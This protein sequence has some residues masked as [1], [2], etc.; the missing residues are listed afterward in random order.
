MRLTCVILRPRVLRA[1][2]FQR[3]RLLLEVLAGLAL[4]SV[5]CC[6]LRP[7]SATG[8]SESSVRHYCRGCRH[9][10]A[11]LDVA[12]SPQPLAA[13][14]GAATARGGAGSAGRSAASTACRRLL[15][16]ACSS[17]LSV[18]SVCAVAMPHSF[19]YRAH[20]RHLFAREFGQ[21]G[22]IPLSTYLHV[23]KVGD[24][25][26]KHR[27]RGGRVHRPAQGSA[28]HASPRRIDR[29]NLID[30]AAACDGSCSCS[31]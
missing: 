15:T 16:L 2:P 26:T 23:Y 27:Q 30:S 12:R 28:A 6:V 10:A 22:N 5:P 11:A 20:T 25:S 7:A 31:G 14:A 13:S 9:A 8:T 19:G 3:V 1:R 29:S 4:L 21:H 18:S 24:V 17:V